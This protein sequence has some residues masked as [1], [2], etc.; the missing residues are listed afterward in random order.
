MGGPP[1]KGTKADQRLKANNP[2]AGKPKAAAPKPVL[3]T[4]KPMAPKKGGK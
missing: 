4:T 3:P 2:N 1:S